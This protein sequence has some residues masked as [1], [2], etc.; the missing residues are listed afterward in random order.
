[1]DF[2][3]IIF[4]VFA[5]VA[6]IQVLYYLGIFSRFAFAKSKTPPKSPEKPVSVVVCARNEAENLRINLPPILEQDYPEFEV[7]VVNDQSVDDTAT[8]LHELQVKHPRLKI[9]NLQM[10]SRS[11]KGKKFALT[12]GIKAAK[13][14][15][16][17]LTDADCRP[18]STRW[19]QQMQAYLSAKKQ[20]LL[21]YG[22]H[23][24]RTGFLNKC[25]RFDTFYTALQYMSF[26]L[27]G[28]PYMGV[29]RNL[30]YARTLFLENP[31]YQKYP[32]LLSGDDDLFIN[33]V[34]RAGNTSVVVDKDSFM[35]S[36]PKI[37]WRSWLF[38]KKRHVTT[39]KYYRF[40]H[41]LLLG[42]LS[43]TH[44]LFY[45]LAILLLATGY[46]WRTIVVIGLCRLLLQYII[47][48][49][50]M[51]KFDER[52]LFLL[53]PVLDFLYVLLYLILAPAVFLNKQRKW[54]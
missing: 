35:Y 28:L 32:H 39:G 42:V 41:K 13:H 44:I 48:F 47:F 33:H 21:A 18:G 31:V 53:S 4:W 23:E 16:L 11:L 36:M 50:S 19:I 15:W 14:E 1:M 9:V 45:G 52:D 54:K 37:T 51:R 38:Q 2:L 27:S 24:K 3:S 22:P 25:I 30:G 12:M 43:A 40:I 34:A 17:L 46:E 6:G 26:A 29:G 8:V 10:G 49:P 7:V 5:M 20:V